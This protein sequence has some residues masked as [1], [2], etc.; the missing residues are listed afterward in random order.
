[1]ENEAQTTKES[2]TAIRGNKM[3]NT[4]QRV[5]GNM[6]NLTPEGEVRVQSLRL[7]SYPEGSP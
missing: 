4:R 3:W 5:Q 2:V 1:M 7:S 6:P